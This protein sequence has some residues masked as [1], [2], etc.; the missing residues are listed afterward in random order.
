M[1]VTNPFGPK[2][3]P[4]DP[5]AYERW[6]SAHARMVRHTDRYNRTKS[7]RAYRL[8]WLAAADRCEHEG[9]AGEA[10]AIRRR[11]G[12]GGTQQSG[13]RTISPEPSLRP[14]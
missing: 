14:S 1:S 6:D 13:R 9:R 7:P 11:Y 5:A 2:K 10:A 8:G 3:D 4:R 12:D